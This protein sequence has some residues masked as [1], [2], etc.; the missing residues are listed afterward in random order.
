MGGA[1][2]A[3]GQRS[4][5]VSV[6]PL[7]FP[8]AKISV[9]V[10]QD[11][12]PLNGENDTGGGVDV[13][14]PNE[15]GLEGFNIVLLDQTGQFGDPAGQLTYDEF[16][17]PVS[18]SLAHTIDPA[19]GLD[20][21]PIS[22]SSA[23]G[24]VGM[25]VTCPKFESDGTTLSPLRGHAVIAN[26]YPGLYEVHTT[27]GAD[28]TARGEEWLQTNTLDGTKDIEAFIKPDEPSYFQEFGPGG[29]HVA[30]GFANPEDHQ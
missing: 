26:M 8:S 7:P 4:V 15:A 22:P 17:M 14:S 28:R 10:F 24:I 2:I 6:Q 18:N 19:T 23:D 29:Y 1:Q 3:A 13:L 16:G 9:F 25:I 21:C 30:V 20:A 12:F 27:P 11:D 5:D